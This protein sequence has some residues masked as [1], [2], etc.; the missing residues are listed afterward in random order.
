MILSGCWSRPCSG[1][2]WA[3]E[4]HECLLKQ[5]VLDC[6]VAIGAAGAPLGLECLKDLGKGG[7]VG[8]M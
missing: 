1:Q 3:G 4:R 6:V 8:S 5:E 2:E 7:G